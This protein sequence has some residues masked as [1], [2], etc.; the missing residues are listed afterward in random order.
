[1]LLAKLKNWTSMLA[2]LALFSLSSYLAPLEEQAED[3]AKITLGQ[4]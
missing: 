3:H 4:K 1:M 2:M